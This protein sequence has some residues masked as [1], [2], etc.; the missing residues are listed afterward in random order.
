MKKILV[1]GSGSGIG[2][3][4]FSR[5]KK[6]TC[7]FP[8]GIS[9]R[10]KKFE[11]QEKIEQYGSYRCDLKSEKEIFEFTEFLKSNDFYL[12]VVYFCAGSGLFKPIS[13]TTIADWDEHFAVNVRGVFL[14][15]KELYPLLKKGNSPFV[16]FIASTASRQGFSNSSAYCASKHALLGLARAIRE[17]WK[18]EGIRIT[19]II[20]GAV[21]TSIWDD[22][23]EFSRED[24]IPADD[25]SEFLK[26]LPEISDKIYPDE[27]TLLPR[28]GLL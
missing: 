2:E 3:S 11:K 27:I 5:L 15:L 24:M 18:R 19:S 20:L 1:V 26:I 23:P 12:D 8:V 25:L 13:E 6:D 21:D 9:R 10:G 17:E 14:I 7:I 4:L 22:R 16:C 28:K